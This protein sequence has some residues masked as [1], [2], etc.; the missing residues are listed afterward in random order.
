M[1]TKIFVGADRV[2]PSCNPA[3]GGKSYQPGFAIFSSME[4][5][6]RELEVCFI[7]KSKIFDWRRIQIGTFSHLNHTKIHVHLFRFVQTRH[8]LHCWVCDIISPMVILCDL[9]VCF[10]A[11]VK[12]IGEGFK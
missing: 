3:P 9:E 11:T 6:L 12:L 1:K 2:L 4:I 8:F 10:I 5:K 7:A